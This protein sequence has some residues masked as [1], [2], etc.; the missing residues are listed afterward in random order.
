M[1]VQ[2]ILLRVTLLALLVFVVVV[3]PLVCVVVVLPLL[4]VKL[5]VAF[6]VS[7]AETVGDIGAVAEASGIPAIGPDADTRAKL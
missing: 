1:R 5:L 6:F 7:S 3:V 4:F 2:V